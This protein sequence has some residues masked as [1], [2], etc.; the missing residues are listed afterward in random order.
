MIS[1]KQAIENIKRFFGRKKGKW[2]F[3]ACVAKKDKSGRYRYKL[4]KNGVPVKEELTWD[5][6]YFRP[7]NPETQDEILKRMKKK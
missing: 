3:W 5:W 4:Y 7:D 1:V 6:W 2:E